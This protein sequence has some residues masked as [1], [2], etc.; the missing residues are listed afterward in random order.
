MRERPI[1]FSSPMVRALLNGTKAQTRRVVN[2]RLYFE[3]G[4]DVVE[5]S[6]AEF[7]LF[8]VDRLDAC[9]Y[10]VPGDRLWVR[11]T[12]YCDHIFAKTQGTPE[13]I[14]QWRKM[15]YFGADYLTPQEWSN[16][17][18][19]AERTPAWRPSIYMPRWAS[20]LTLE[21]TSVRVERLQSISEKDASA[22]GTALPVTTDD[23]PPGKVQPLFQ[24]TRSPMLDSSEK[25]SSKNKYRWAFA[26][27]WESING[28][29]APWASNPWVWVIDFKRV[30]DA[31]A[32]ANG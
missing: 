11:E 10:G 23:C 7:G 4:C 20:R 24:L 30:E 1:L 15:L 2:P 31:K 19:W 5:Q 25:P 6:H 28:K 3:N 32:V 29:R 16:A 8:A 21:V 17:E 27:L 9:P 12:W 14:A 26:C 18:E 13:Q 22:E